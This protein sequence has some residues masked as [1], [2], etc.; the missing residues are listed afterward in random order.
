MDGA[1]GGLRS[2]ITV[3]AIWR[4]SSLAALAAAALAPIYA[5]FFLGFDAGTLAILVISLLLIW[6]HKSNIAI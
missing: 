5:V 4:I 6:R 1:A 3:A 2:G